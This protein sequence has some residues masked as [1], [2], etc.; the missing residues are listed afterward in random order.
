MIKYAEVIHLSNICMNLTFFMSNI[1]MTLLYLPAVVSH[2]TTVSYH[3][4][5]GALLVG[6]RT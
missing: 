1:A 3:P 4:L 5:G 2:Y 6:R